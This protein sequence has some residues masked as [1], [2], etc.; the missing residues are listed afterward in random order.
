MSV[1]K[2]FAALAAT[3]ALSVTLVAC[4]G[5]GNA[6]GGGADTAKSLA[7][8]AQYNPQPYENLRDGGTLTTAIPEVSTQ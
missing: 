5:G 7:E 1:V 6:N 8:Q 2:R 3:A 4:A